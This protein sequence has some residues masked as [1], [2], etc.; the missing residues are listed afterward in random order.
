[1]ISM[2]KLGLFFVLMTPNVYAEHMPAPTDEFLYHLKQSLVKVTTT[3]KSGGHSFGTGV[4]ISKDHVVTNCHVLTNANGISISKWG[5]EYAPLSLQ[6]DWKHDL[7]ILKFEWADLKPVVMSDSDNLHY[8]Q[9]VISISMPTD[10]PAPYVALSNI[11]ALYPMDGAEVVRTEAAFSIGASG[12]P[13]FD[14]AG[15]LIGISTFKSPGRKAYY[16]NMPVKWIKALL[17]HESTDLNALHDLPFWDA[18]EEKRPF[19]MQIVMPFQNSRWV[20][21]REIA[22]HWV[23]DEPKN[24]EA[25]YYLGASFQHLGDIPHAV[26]HFRK[27]LALHDM[28]PA[29]LSALALIAQSQGD[30]VELSKIKSQVKEISHE[31]LEGL[32]DTLSANQLSTN[33]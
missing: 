8:E 7:C 28:H 29:S 15:K 30:L 10:S 14:Y 4:A 19:F 31:A 6:A 32:N 1:M 27:A 3:T 16:Y 22:L 5:V 13:I 26:Q 23:N 9:P 24:A 18:P 21:V 12:S 25:W 33:R 17:T 20:D 11:K 2:N